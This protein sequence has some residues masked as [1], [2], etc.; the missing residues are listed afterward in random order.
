MDDAAA[1]GPEAHQSS[2]PLTRRK[3]GSFLA[4]REERLVLPRSRRPDATTRG[5]CARRCG[6]PRCTAYATLPSRWRRDDP[7]PD[8]PNAEGRRDTPVS[9]SRAVPGEPRRGAAG[10]AA[11]TSQKFALALTRG[12]ALGLGT[13]PAF[14]ESRLLVP[15]TPGDEEA[16]QASVENAVCRGRGELP[17]QTPCVQA[18]STPSHAARALSLGKKVDFP[19]TAR[20]IAPATLLAGLRAPCGARPE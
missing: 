2:S 9:Q 12:V 18:R 10:S 5:A 17:Q 7:R 20:D 8:R 1:A 19:R 15:V 14:V 4:R 6:G 11:R 3:E 13:R 16:R